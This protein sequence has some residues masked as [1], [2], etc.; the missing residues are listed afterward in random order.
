VG[1]Y[2]LC[3]IRAYYQLLARD[4]V[5]ASSLSRGKRENLLDIYTHTYTH[6]HPHL[7]T[8]TPTHLQPHVHSHTN[9]PSPHHHTQPHMHT[10]HA[11]LHAPVHACSMRL[12]GPHEV[13]LSVKGEP[14]IAGAEALPQV[15][16]VRG[17]NWVLAQNPVHILAL[18][19]GLGLGLGS[20][21]PAPGCCVGFPWFKRNAWDC[22]GRVCHMHSKKAPP[23]LL[24]PRQLLARLQPLRVPPPFGQNAQCP[25]IGCLHMPCAQMA[26]TVWFW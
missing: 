21:R 4:Q 20:C 23:A 7:H 17:Q 14:R 8:S 24:P 10:L 18:G 15:T 2:R 13:P 16:P 19:L 3:A 1:N 22:A 9:T 25:Q 26:R 5:L 11:L 6:P 12:L